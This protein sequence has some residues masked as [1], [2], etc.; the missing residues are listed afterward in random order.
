MQ[1]WAKNTSERKNDTSGKGKGRQIPD[2]TEWKLLE[3][4]DFNLEELIPVTE[5]VRTNESDPPHC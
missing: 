5:D 4:W 3:K 1:V 2:E